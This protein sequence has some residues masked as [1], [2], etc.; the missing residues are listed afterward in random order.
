MPRGE[1]AVLLQAVGRRT[2]IKIWPRVR[3]AH[4]RP[5][6][7]RV[8]TGRTL[9]LAKFQNRPRRISVSPPSGFRCRDAHGLVI[10]HRLK[11]WLPYMLWQ[12]RCVGDDPL[13]E[14]SNFHFLA[15]ELLNNHLSQTIE[16]G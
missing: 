5:N 1:G 7:C 8:H 3:R 13:F 15:A 9:R 14:V 16:I 2:E 4:L 6:A 12:K 10:F 11:Y